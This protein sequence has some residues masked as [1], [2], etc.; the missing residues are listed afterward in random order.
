[1]TVNTLPDDIFLEIFA[2]YLSFYYNQYDGHGYWLSEHTI[3]WQRLVQV[4]TRWRDIIYGS[5]CYL[6]LHL[7]CSPQTPFTKNYGRW[8]EFPLALHYT[9]QDEYYPIDDNDDVVVWN[10]IDQFVIRIYARAGR[11]LVHEN[12]KGLIGLNDLFFLR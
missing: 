12:C 1:M 2:F 11:H 7:S 3:A 5:P 8:P 10:S 4:C 9:I 6:D